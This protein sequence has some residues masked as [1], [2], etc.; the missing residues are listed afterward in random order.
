[1][2]KVDVVWLSFHKPEIL[3]RGYWDQAILEEMFADGDYEHHDSTDGLE[4]GAIV[5]INGRTHTKK[6]DTD[7]INDAIKSL[8]WCLFIDTGDEEAIF[9]WRDVKHPHMRVWIMLPRV[10][11]HDDTSYKLVNGYRPDTRRILREIGQQ[12]RTLDWFFAGQVTHERRQDCAAS[13]VMMMNKSNATTLK[14]SEPSYRFVET[15]TFGEEKIDYTQYITYMAQAKFAPCPSGPE[16]PDSF[17]VYEALE[18]GAVPIVDAYSTNHRHPGF[19]S[20]VLGDDIPFPVITEWDKLP[21]LMPHLLRDYP[22][23]ANQTF[24][25]WLQFKRSMKYKLEEDTREL[26]R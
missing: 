13:L 5:I 15:R 25:W 16:T 11:Q 9:P 26:S 22:R 10:N 1:M 8:S 17:R 14:A 20:Y 21:D 18:S 7:A 2:G 3:A 23:I 24:A 4:G 19:W 12:D 6:E